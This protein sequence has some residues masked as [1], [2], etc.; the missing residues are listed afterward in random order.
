M[1]NTPFNHLSGGWKMRYTLA[2]TLLQ[3][4]DIMILDEFTNFLDLLGIIWLQKYLVD[5]Q[6]RSEKT[7]LVVSHDR[8]FI[9][10]VCQGIILVQ[11]QK[12]VYFGGNL[13]AYEEDLRS[14]RLRLTRIKMPKTSRLPEWKRRLRAT[15]EPER[16]M[17]TTTGCG[18][19]SPVR[20]GSMTAWVCR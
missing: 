12:L 5:P 10:H 15:S 19:P 7:V 11:D 17:G 16:R 8:E 4:A 18:R 20:R 3:D 14:R 9:D 13:T 2:S 6:S 1:V